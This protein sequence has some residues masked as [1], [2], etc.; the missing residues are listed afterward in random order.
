MP[1]GGLY[2]TGGVTNKAMEFLK[3]DNAF[4][5]AFIDKVRAAVC[6]KGRAMDVSRCTA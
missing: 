6:P 2:L 4:M 3:K 1:F 5:D